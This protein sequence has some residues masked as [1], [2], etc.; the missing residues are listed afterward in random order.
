MERRFTADVAMRQLAT[1]DRS[2]LPSETYAEFAIKQITLIKT[3]F[4]NLAER[5]MIAMVKRKLDLE[6]AQFC[7]EETTVNAFVSELIAYDNLR[8]LHIGRRQP[9]ATRSSQRTYAQ[10]QS[11]NQPYPSPDTRDY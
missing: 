10:S 7:R 5:A 6:G 4:A 1:E 2:R 8:A 11:Y 9:Q 3:S